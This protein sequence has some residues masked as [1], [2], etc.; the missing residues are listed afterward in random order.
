ME[1]GRDVGGEVSGGQSASVG[2]H[3]RPKH[4]VVV[5]ASAV[6]AHGRYVAVLL[7]QVFEALAGHGCP[8][9]GGVEVVDVCL[10]VLAVVNFHGHGIDMRL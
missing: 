6:V 9:D 5:V 3:E 2:A 10:V 7:H 4:A 8:F 1:G